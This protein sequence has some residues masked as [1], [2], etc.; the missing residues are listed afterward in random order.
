MIQRALFFLSS[1][2]AILSLSAAGAIPTSGPSVTATTYECSTRCYAE[3][4]ARSKWLHEKNHS[5]LVC[6]ASPTDLGKHLDGHCAALYQ[7]TAPAGWSVRAY[8][9]YPGAPGTLVAC[10]AV[11]NKCQKPGPIHALWT[12]PATCRGA[13]PS[14]PTWM[15][16]C[17][18]S[19]QFAY[20]GG[21]VLFRTGGPRPLCRAGDTLGIPDAS[22]P[23]NDPPAQMCKSTQKECEIAP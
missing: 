19:Q 10:T 8:L 20:E 9:N 14:Y 5:F 18:A 22:E 23:F 21:L 13:R 17:A 3:G 16:L 11:G 2:S 12:C 6:A 15:S 1:W 4:P 7:S